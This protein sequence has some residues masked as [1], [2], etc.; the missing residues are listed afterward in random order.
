MKLKI[1]FLAL[2]AAGVGASIA[3]GSPSDDG[4]GKRCTTT[5]AA[6]TT[7]PTT[8][9]V[10]S[11]HEDDDG[12]KHG[13]KACTTSG[14]TAGTTG[15]LRPGCRRVELR[16]TLGAATVTMSVDRSSSK[17]FRNLAGTQVTLAVPAGPGRVSARVCTDAAGKQ[18]L[19][20]DSL[21]VGKTSEH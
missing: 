14:T 6:T 12:D 5:S 13:G 4:H 11:K 7:V 21:K 3:L 10:R 1:L 2:F 18:T 16:G 19:Q 20:L 17:R 9:T 15:Q 8:T